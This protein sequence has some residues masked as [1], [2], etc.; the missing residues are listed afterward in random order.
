MRGRGESLRSHPDGAVEAWDDVFGPGRVQADVSLAPMTSLKSGGAAEWLLETAEP[1]DVVRAVRTARLLDLPVTLL[2]GGSNVLVGCGGV[3]GLVVRFRHGVVSL[4]KPGVVRADAGVSLNA[5]VRWTA[6]RGWAG[7]ERWAGTPG[8]VGGALNGN[9]HF[10]GRLIGDQVIAV[11]VVD[12]AGA[13]CRL[14]SAEMRFEYDRSRVR[15]SGEGV[16]WAE[17]SVVTGDPARIRATARDSLR[18]RKRTQPLTARSAGC[19]FQNPDPQRDPVPSD[20]PA[21]AGALI[22]RAGL[23]NRSVGL[24]SVSSVHGNFI[25]TDGGASPTEIRELIELCREAV[26]EQFGVVLRDEIVYLGEF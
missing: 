22:D 17:F 5:L 9:A 20:I 19:I 6:A 15:T 10:Q 7:L 2:G 14:E 1:D 11:G 21:S 23:K 25:V 24:A 3:R 13:S 12:R 4:V 18:Y 26:R 16:L 8:T